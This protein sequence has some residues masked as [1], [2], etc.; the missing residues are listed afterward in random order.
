MHPESTIK[1]MQRLA[2]HQN[3]I[4]FRQES[5]GSIRISLSTIY[6]IMERLAM[7]L[8]FGLNVVCI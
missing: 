8:E 5:S 6:D 4:E 1:L 7:V 3:G 2:L